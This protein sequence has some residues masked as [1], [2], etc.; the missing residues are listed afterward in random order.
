VPVLASPPMKWEDTGAIPEA[1]WCKTLEPVAAEPPFGAA[2]LQK[3]GLPGLQVGA[4][5]RRHPSCL[6]TDLCGLIDLSLTETR[7]DRIFRVDGEAYFVQMDATRPLPFADAVFDWVYAEHFIEHITLREAIGWLREVRR[8][9]RP[10]GL[11][12]LTTPDLGRYAAAYAA[13][14]QAF[15]AAHSARLEK[16]GFPPMETRPAW[17]VNQIFQFWGHKWIYDADELRHAAVEAGF[18]AGGFR[19]CAFREGRLPK[20]AALDYELR[21]DETIYVEL[22]A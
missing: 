13:G 17:M 7:M 12:R 2:L 19:R 14:D 21:N 1:M 15:F 3:L 10:D 5:D 8:L 11:V 4:L 9:L 16:Y 18:P 22:S 20:V 6:N